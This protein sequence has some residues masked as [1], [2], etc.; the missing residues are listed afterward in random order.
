MTNLESDEVTETQPTYKLH[1]LRSIVWATFWGT[2]LAGGII[3]ALNYFRTGQ[4]SAGRNAVIGGFLGAVAL[5][6]LI[7]V[8]PDQV[9]DRVPSAVFIIPQL[10]IIHLIAKKLQSKLIANHTLNGGDFSSLWSSFGIGLGC[11][12]FFLVTFLSMN[13]I[14]GPDYGPHINVGNDEVYYSGDATEDEARRLGTT[15]RGL[16]FFQGDGVSVRLESSDEKYTISFV[17]VNNAWED[18]KMVQAFKRMCKSLTNSTFP[19]PLKINLCDN[20]FN[21]KKSFVIEE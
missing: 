20:Y 3:M 5:L 18:P 9:F 13:L 12:A 6:V 17:L 14:L 4:K 10:L 16:T 19:T 8:I 15:L 7:F 11:L 2:P 1:S 21:V